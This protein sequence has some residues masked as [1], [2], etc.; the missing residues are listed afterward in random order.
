M[1]EDFFFCASRKT[2]SVDLSLET[3]LGKGDKKPQRVF[4]ESRVN[5]Y[6]SFTMT[7]DCSLDSKN[8]V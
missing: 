2:T 3:L 7:D 1:E 8:M 6:W 4:I 5:A